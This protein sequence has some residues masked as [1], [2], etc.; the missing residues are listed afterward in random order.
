MHYFHS[1]QN[2]AEFIFTC[3]RVKHIFDMLEHML[4]EKV[5]FKTVN[6]FPR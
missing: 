3:I 6:E 4:Y 2:H 1:C 5:A